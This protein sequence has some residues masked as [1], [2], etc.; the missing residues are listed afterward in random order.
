[1]GAALALPICPLTADEPAT[2]RAGDRYKPP[3]AGRGRP[4]G[5]DLATTAVFSFAILIRYD[6]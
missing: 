5:H 2:G 6:S 3:A 1:M 4:S